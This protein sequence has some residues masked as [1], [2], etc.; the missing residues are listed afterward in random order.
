[1]EGWFDVAVASGVDVGLRREGLGKKQ[2]NLPGVLLGC[3]LEPI[4][5]VDGVPDTVTLF[6]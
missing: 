2:L 6:P 3:V 1:M 4:F 5:W